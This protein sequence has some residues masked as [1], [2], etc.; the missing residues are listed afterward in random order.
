MRNLHV[1][2]R[3]SRALSAFAVTSAAAAGACLTGAVLMLTGAPN[4]APEV[5]YSVELVEP[6]MASW[7][8]PDPRVVP[9][10]LAVSRHSGALRG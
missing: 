2:G 6:P 4:A 3:A 1:S 9:L 8:T 7:T 10:P 5:S